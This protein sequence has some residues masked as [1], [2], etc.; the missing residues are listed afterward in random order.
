M[1]LVAH[2]NFVSRIALLFFEKRSNGRSLGHLID[3]FAAKCC[4]TNTDL[5]NN[6]VILEI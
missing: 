3:L 6:L 4:S 5:N 1:N 2:L